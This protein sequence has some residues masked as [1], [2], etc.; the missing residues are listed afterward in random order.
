[1]R[2]TITLLCFFLSVQLFSQADIVG[3]EDCDI[4]D[5]PW[6]AAINANGYLCGAS[7]INEYWILTAAHCVEN[8]GNINSPEEV[9][10][11]VGSSNAYAGMYGNS[12][13]QYDVEEVISHPSFGNYAAGGWGGS[14]NNDIA[15]L[16][17][18][19]PIVFNDDVQPISIICSDQVASGA[20][21]VGVM[22]TVTGWGN[23]TQG[24]DGSNVLQFIQVPII[25]NNDPNVDY[26]GFQNPNSNTQFLAG[27]VQGGMDSCQGDSGGP[28][29][30]RN[31][32]DTEWLLIGITS[33]GNGCANPGYPGVYTKISNYI[34]WIRNNTDDCVDPDLSQACDSS[35]GI[36]GCMDNTACNYNSQATVEGCCIF[37]TDPIY[38]CYGDC[39]INSDNDNYC[40]QEDNCPYNSNASQSDSDNDG[41]GNAC[42]N[43]NGV[44]NPDQLDSDGDGDGDECDSSPLDIQDLKVAGSV[45]KTIDLY[46]R[47]LN[48]EYNSGAKFHFYQ[49][50]SVK[51]TLKF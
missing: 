37:N 12:G 38:D 42:D 13:D 46:G 2:T 7:I 27:T 39:L 26:G 34:N 22:T 47:L 45:I 3:G 51:K 9:S 19:S 14:M 5:Y 17:L 21:D 32:E 31:V 28:V 4:S 15:L 16:K 50:G 48:C 33:W 44:Y 24:G 49:D 30:V 8:N 29:V 36:S 40:D 18:A 11:H 25:S 43:C 10:V 6:Q 41:V 35:N 23:T 1:M 20:Q